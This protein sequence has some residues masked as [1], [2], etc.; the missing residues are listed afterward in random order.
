MSKKDKKVKVKTK[1]L[2]VDPWVQEWCTEHALELAHYRGLVVAI[3][4]QNGIVTI[5][6]DLENL[7]AQVGFLRRSIASE[8]AAIDVDGALSMIGRPG[9]RVM[10]RPDS[11][12]MDPHRQEAKAP[13]PE[14]TDPPP[15]LSPPID[16]FDN[17][18]TLDGARLPEFEVGDVGTFNPK[19]EDKATPFPSPDKQPKFMPRRS[20]LSDVRLDGVSNPGIRGSSGRGIRYD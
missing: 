15:P 5:A 10:K 13:V 11:P 20:P 3:H 8:C 17:E 18:V 19:P 16:P 9:L 7:T 4:P 14:K 12:N 6:R 1:R 2:K